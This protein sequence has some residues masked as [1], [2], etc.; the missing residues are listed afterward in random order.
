MTVAQTQQHSLLIGCCQIVFSIYMCYMIAA[1]PM[2]S[3]VSWI[4]INSLFCKFGQ[5]PDKQFPTYL[6]NCLSQG[7]MAVQPFHW[8][9]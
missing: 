3:S 6:T 7:H 5:N 9:T 4:M 1:V 8:L 2:L